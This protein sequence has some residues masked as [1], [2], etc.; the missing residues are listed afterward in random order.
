MLKKVAN[1]FICA[2]SQQKVPKIPEIVSFPR[3]ISHV[4]HQFR[5]FAELLQSFCRALA[6]FLQTFCRLFAAPVFIGISRR[7]DFN[8]VERLLD[9]YK[10][11][12][13]VR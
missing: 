9:L 7:Q 5:L 3:E 4:A 6:D 1:R 10:G 13:A 11:G 8:E 2:K 12:G